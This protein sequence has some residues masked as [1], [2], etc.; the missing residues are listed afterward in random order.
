MGNILSNEEN[1]EEIEQEPVKKPS[2]KRQ[3]RVKK[4]S[5]AKQKSRKNIPKKEI[6]FEE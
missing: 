2:K 5:A 6:E 4:A 3:T 1:L